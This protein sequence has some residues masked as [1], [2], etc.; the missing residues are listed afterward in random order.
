MMEKS[1]NSGTPGAR[2]EQPS[3]SPID[4]SVK[5]ELEEASA[6][7]L[8][9]TEEDVESGPDSELLDIAW[10]YKWLALLCVCAFP[11]GQNCKFILLIGIA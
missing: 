7:K 1:T 9:Y 3:G 2:P 6:P 10:R 4:L 8:H 11:L 5:K